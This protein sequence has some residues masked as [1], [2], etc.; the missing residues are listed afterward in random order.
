MGEKWFL[1][2]WPLHFQQVPNHWESKLLQNDPMISQIDPNIGN[3][4]SYR[5]TAPLFGAPGFHRCDFWMPSRANINDRATSNCQ[6]RT[7]IHVDPDA[8]YPAMPWFLYRNQAQLGWPQAISMGF[9]M[10]PPFYIPLP[11]HDYCILALKPPL[12]QYQYYIHIDV[13]VMSHIVV[14]SC[15]LSTRTKQPTNHNQTN[16]DVP[17]IPGSW[18][19]MCPR[20]PTGTSAT[21]A[22]RRTWVLHHDLWWLIVV[23]S[24]GFFMVNGWPIING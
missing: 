1:T 9:V 4:K 15:S 24:C 17:M 3:P 21:T 7:V 11:N 6:Q 10:S 20:F 19:N 12:L 8:I 23:N 2:K 13:G 22:R 16:Q 14:G 18:L 5:S